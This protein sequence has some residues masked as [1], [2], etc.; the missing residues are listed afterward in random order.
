MSP[1]CLH[2]DKNSHLTS[3]LD[4]DAVVSEEQDSAEEFVETSAGWKLAVGKHKSEKY[5]NIVDL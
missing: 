3:V 4:G 2:S 5:K 1:L